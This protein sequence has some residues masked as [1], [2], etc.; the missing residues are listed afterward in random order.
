MG[1]AAKTTYGLL[2]LMELAGV[3]ASGER[4]QVAEIAAR[5][6]IPERYLEQMMA[7]LRRAGLLRSSRG[8]RGGYQ[9]ARPAASIDLAEVLECLEGEA[10]L[11]SAGEEASGS[12]ERQ[13]LQEL[14][15]SLRQQRLE[16][17]QHT[18][19]AQLLEQRDALQQAQ[20]MYFI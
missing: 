18:S 3:E 13:V 19:L 15:Q 14:A 9:L 6:G 10:A 12:P 8:P 20:A 5:Q 2:A 7:S 11:G 16:R 4:L 17:L 1:F